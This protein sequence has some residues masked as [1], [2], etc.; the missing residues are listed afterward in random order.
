MHKGYTKVLNTVTLNHSLY[1]EKANTAEVCK[2]WVL[3]KWVLEEKEN[4]S[5]CKTPF[6]DPHSSLGSE[7]A[8]KETRESILL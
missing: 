7:R 6:G 2:P 1:I 5:Y 4:H 3:T 8:P